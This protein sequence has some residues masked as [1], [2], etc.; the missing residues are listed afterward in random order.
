[1]R[2]RS[3][4]ALACAAAAL[5]FALAGCKPAKVTAPPRPLALPA[6]PAGKLDNL[7]PLELEIESLL[8][9]AAALP[10]AAAYFKD[11]F[12][13]A[14]LVIDDFD[15]LAFTATIKDGKASVTRGIDPSK[16]PDLVVPLTESN[17]RHMLRFLEDGVITEEEEYQIFYV[18][19]I[20]SYRSLLT[21]DVMYDPQVQERL[22]T[23]DFMHVVL[24]NEKGFRYGHRSDPLGA[25]IVKVDG[26]W[27]I[28][29]GL[30]GEPRA[31]LEVTVAQAKEFTR[32]MREGTSR[33]DL[34][35]QEQQELLDRVKKFLDAV[36]VSRRPR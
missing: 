8:Q 11:F 1:M 31:R 13:T 7:A 4:A 22:G 25:T 19:F 18:T 23:P 28:F 6:L 10:A 26:Q 33:K 2:I 29:P 20:P 35:K 17:C 32:L 30:A 34:S 36:T 14:Y 27:M 24:K 12:A 15:N 3:G 16:W 9:Q 21:R 5:T